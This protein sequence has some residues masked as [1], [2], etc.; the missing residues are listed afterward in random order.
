LVVRVRLG[1]G[2]CK[3]TETYFFLDLKMCV[4]D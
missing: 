3:K 4:S 1:L 2:F